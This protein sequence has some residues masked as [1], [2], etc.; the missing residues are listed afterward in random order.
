[1]T[2]NPQ[3]TLQEAKDLYEILFFNPVIGKEQFIIKLQ[4]YIAGYE[5]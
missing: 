4:N 2:E 5:V 3:L 1:M